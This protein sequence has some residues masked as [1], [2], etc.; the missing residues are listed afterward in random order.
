MSYSMLNYLLYPLQ[1]YKGP[2]KGLFLF[3]LWTHTILAIVNFLLAVITIKYAFKSMFKKH[4]KIAP[5][6]VF[7]WLY[8]AVT[9]WLIYFFM[10]WLNK[11]A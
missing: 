4:R 7:V 9:G 2:Y 10:Q 1:P 8:V 5:I 11:N 3:I 6:I